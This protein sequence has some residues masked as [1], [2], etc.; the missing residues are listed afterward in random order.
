[1][2]WFIKNP[3]FRSEEIMMKRWLFW[4]ICLGLISSCSLVPDQIKESTQSL[5]ASPEEQLETAETYH[6]QVVQYYQQ[7][8]FEQALPLAEKAYRL[9][10]EVLG[11]KHPDTLTSL[12]NLASIYFMATKYKAKLTKPSNIWKN[13]SKA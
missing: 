11:E 7:G 1:L 5:F 2:G 13:S 6:N 3:T 9:R 8:Q 4:I 12:N 10:K